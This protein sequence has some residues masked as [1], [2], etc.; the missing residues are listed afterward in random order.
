MGKMV[1]KKIMVVFGTRPEAI[2]M[3]PVILELQKN[4]DW[5]ETSIVVTAQHR[6]ML[7][8]ILKSFGIVSNYDL[9]IMTQ[10]QSLDL[11]LTKAH[12][13]IGQLLAK[14]SPDL[15]LVQGDTTTT[16][17]ASVA[18]YHHQIKLGHVEAGLRSFDKYNPFPEEI[19]RTI[20]DS[21]ADLLFAPTEVSR[22]NLIKTGLEEDKIFVTGNTVVD[23]LLEISNEDYDFEDK[24][25]EK[26]DFSGKKIILLTTHRRENYLTGEMKNIMES[27]NTLMRRHKN[28]E[29]VFPV[30]LNPNVRS[31]VQEKLE[32]SKQVHVVEP[33][34]Y[35]DLVKVM[36]NSYLI[37]TDSGGIQE[38]GPTFG[39]PVLV[40]RKVTERPE[41]I[42]AGVAK[43]VGTN[44]ETITR[45]VG[46]LLIDKKAYGSMTRAVNPYGD[47]QAARRIVQIIKDRL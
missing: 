2:K 5:F 39:K 16:M 26:V 37:L 36:K 15:V 41:G 20:T 28:L 32:K 9:N 13:G 46:N 21:I 23:A 35:K 11:I 18:V 43:L 10:D 4:S 27:L 12:T 38:E 34:S 8:Q 3:A 31:I 42:T 7:D 45:E 44:K 19:N 33:L 40:L 22:A 30:H 24:T 14:L 25:L 1:K 47:G 17:A 29:F 6:E